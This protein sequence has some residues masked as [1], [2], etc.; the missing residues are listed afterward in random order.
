MRGHSGR[1]KGDR[2]RQRETERQRDFI[3]NDIAR[4][5]RPVKDR[6][7]FAS[8]REV[9]ASEREVCTTERQRGVY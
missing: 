8:E 6:E 2:E 3:R 7:I 4:E 1:S 9:F 5:S